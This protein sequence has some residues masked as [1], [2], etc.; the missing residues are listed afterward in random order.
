MTRLARRYLLLGR[1]ATLCVLLVLT[2]ISISAFIR[3]SNAG[4]GCTDWPQ[5]YGSKMRQALQ[6]METKAADGPAVV[7]VRPLH[8]VAAV[9]ALILIVTMLL[10]CFV[11]QPILWR[12]GRIALAL[13]AL[14]LFL[15]VLGRWSSGAR[16]PAVT[17]GN[18][19]AGFAMLALCWRLR[20][21]AHAAG[22][23]HGAVQRL[24]G[25]GVVVLLCQ[26]ALGGL[27]SVAFAGLSCTS[28]PSCG[29]DLSPGWPSLEALNPWLEPTVLVGSAGNPQ[30]AALH[31]AHRY[32]ALIVLLVLVPLSISALN[33]GRRNMAVVLLSLLAIEAALGMLMVISG[34]PLW[35]EL[36]H[37][38]GAALLLTLMFSL[39]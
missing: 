4:L 8:R 22:G 21:K 27:V 3:L 18:L 12:E 32:G 24:A 23:A 33:S 1:I 19:L 11:E 16:V 28:F 37:N 39:V 38:L 30:G 29:G 14:A 15:A 2:V 20:R 34:L 26:I 9:A 17:I 5:C 7:T 25:L 36:G 13:L 35:A 6:G 10:I 31:M